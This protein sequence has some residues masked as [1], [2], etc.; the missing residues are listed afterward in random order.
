MPYGDPEAMKA[1]LGPETAAILVEP[2]QGEGGVVVPPKG[3]LQELRELA[4][5]HGCLLIFDE[6]QTGVWAYGCFSC[7]AP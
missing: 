2:L 5:A 4:D 3:Y 6:I 7:A 1:A